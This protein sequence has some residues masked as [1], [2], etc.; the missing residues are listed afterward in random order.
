VV[1]T[2]VGDVAL[3]PELLPATVAAATGR[4]R[5]AN[6]VVPALEKPF[7]VWLVPYADGVYRRRFLAI[8]DGQVPTMMVLRENRDGSLAWSVY[9]LSERT[10]EALNEARKG[11]LLYGR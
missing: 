6:F 5:F 10:E 4:E 7:E 9:E 8:F 1:E 3:R 11:M 2:P